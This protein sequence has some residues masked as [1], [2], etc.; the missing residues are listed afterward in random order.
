MGSATPAEP[1]DAG[2]AGADAVE[3]P[4]PDSE[5]WLWVADDV[6]LL[7][8]GPDTTQKLR[9]AA[10]ALGPP[11]QVEVVGGFAR[12]AAPKSGVRGGAQ[13][14]AGIYDADGNIV[15]LSARNDAALAAAPA[16][17]D[18]RPDGAARSLERA[19]YGGFVFA[20]FG[21]NLLELPS[22]L[23][24]L[25][26]DDDRPIVL[27]ALP[28]SE[29]R[30]RPAWR[31]M[32][33]LLE[34]RGVTRDRLVLLDRPYRFGS[35]TVPQSTI[36][37]NRSV[38]AGW[39]DFYR[40]VLK[41]LPLPA[42]GRG[43]RVYLSRSAY[44]GSRAAPA[45]ETELEARLERHGFAIVHPQKLPIAEQIAVMQDAE[46]I[47]GLDGS[48]MHMAAFA[49]PGTTVLTLDTRLLTN[50]VMIEAAAGLRGRHLFVD[51]G[52]AAGWLL[53]VDGIER[54]IAA[55]MTGKGA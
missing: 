40:D 45:N 16:T 18:Y 4:L 6:G 22:R 13:F 43:A 23:W 29:D 20:Q 15:A 32:G 8:F 51:T 34:T 11:T 49:Q 21:H 5:G 24:A 48:A 19:V 3:L 30:L 53:D 52:G 35:L 54:W 14:R 2:A 44:A 36:V 42:G 9:R 28:G 7:G 41:R 12:P 26:P 31:Y 10:I 33:P 17:T 27:H 46:I 38:R 25:A 47:A 55:A 1:G 50:Q 39:H 37:I